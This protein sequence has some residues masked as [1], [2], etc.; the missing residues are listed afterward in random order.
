MITVSAPPPPP[1]PQPQPPAG[2]AAAPEPARGRRWPTVVTSLVLLAL[3]MFAQSFRFP[4]DSAVT[5]PMVASGD[6]S[7]AVDA[8]SFTVKVDEVRFAKAIGDGAED[9]GL[10]DFAPETEYIEANGV[11]VVVFMEVTATEKQ[12]TTFE[13]RLDSGDENVYASTSWLY[14]TFGSVDDGFPPG[15]PIKGA[16]AFEVPE[17]ALKDPV[18]QMTISSGPGQRLAGEAHVKLGLSGDE[19]KKAI[20]GAEETL[21]VPAPEMQKV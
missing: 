15:I 7:A 21:D 12:L 14:N 16:A 5:E 8:G 6:A 3:L 18:V 20:D 4:N 10:S 9:S 2:H 13:S 17:K 11:W 19:L 1:P